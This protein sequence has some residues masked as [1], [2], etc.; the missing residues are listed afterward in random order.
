M[1]LPQM[2]YK[3]RLQFT[4]QYVLHERNGYQSIPLRYCRSCLSSGRRSSCCWSRRATPEPCS[5]VTSGNNS[6]SQTLTTSSS[7][8][9]AD[10]MHMPLP[11]SIFWK[12]GSLLLVAIKSL[13][14]TKKIH[15]IVSIYMLVLL[16]CLHILG[17]NMYYPF[18]RGFS[19]SNS[20]MRYSV[21]LLLLD[22]KLC[23]EFYF[24]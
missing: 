15:V 3:D 18:F 13:Y 12:G 20:F 6:S 4:V 10:C 23:R 21:K 14:I 24:Y 19:I 8:Y 11:V 2:N 22:I 17:L 1:V 5:S 7:E 16:V 9:S